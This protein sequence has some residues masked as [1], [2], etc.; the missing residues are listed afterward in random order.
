MSMA[1]FEWAYKL[2]VFAPF[3]LMQLCAPHMEKAGGGV[4]VNISSMAGDNT[5]ARMASYGSSK[6][7]ISHL[8]RNTAFDLGPKKIRS[9]PLPWAPSEPQHLKACLRQRSRKPC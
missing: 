2:N 7:A 1:D 9:M 4:I 5:N 8:T 6:A 3:R